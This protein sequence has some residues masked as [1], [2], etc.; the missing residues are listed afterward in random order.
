MS[1]KRRNRPFLPVKPRFD[2]HVRKTE[3]C[4]EWIGS[5]SHGYGQ[6]S[7]SGR[8]MRASRVSYMLHRGAIPE[9]LHV[10]HKCDNTACVRPDHLFLG[11]HADNMADAV[12]KGRI[13]S[14]ERAP[15]AK[16]TAAGV[17]EIRRR[18]SEGARQATIAREFGIHQATVSSI[19]TGRKWAR[20]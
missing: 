4:W 18:L 15:G 7:V 10:L 3:G 8:P 11:T 2:R 12:A 1:A 20:I 9:G 13:R 19:G 5:K 6:M 14:G 17:L 16:L